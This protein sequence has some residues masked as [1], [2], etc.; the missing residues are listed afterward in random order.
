MKNLL[1]LFI[2]LTSINKL[3][4]QSNDKYELLVQVSNEMNKNCPITIDKETRLDKTNAIKGNIFEYVFTLTNSKK[5]AVNIAEIK[6]YVEKQSI[7]NAKSNPKM[8]NFRRDKITLSYYYKDK[9]GL[10]LFQFK[11]TP[12]QYCN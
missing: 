1:L 10:F 2:F 3:L 12:N 5:A 7:N 4:G 8:N 9:D 11:I 6:K